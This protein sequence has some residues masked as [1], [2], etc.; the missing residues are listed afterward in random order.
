VPLEAGKDD[1]SKDIMYF[2][3][4]G[5]EDLLNRLLDKFM[6]L[7]NVRFKDDIKFDLICVIP[8]SEKDGINKNM[9][10]FAEH[11]SKR[12]SIPFKQILRR[13]RLVE[14]QHE[15]KTSEERFENVKDSIEITEDVKG[16]NV[17]VLDN[18]C[19]TGANCREVY[20]QLKKAGAG[21]IFFF[22]FGLGYKAKH[23]DFDFN[24]TYP[25][26]ASKIIKDYNWPNTIHMKEEDK[27]LYMAK[28]QN[29]K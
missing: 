20:D 12:T 29:I 5:Y 16:K 3:K 22:C 24:E 17:L 11:A 13:K 1:F 23:L 14:K 9:V 8:T 21:D 4:Y 15:L 28:K 10:L 2:Y 6:N 25:K 26:K 19:S 7:F 18:T 27:Q